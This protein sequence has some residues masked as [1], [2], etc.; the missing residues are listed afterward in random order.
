MP[1]V[2]VRKIAK[3][4]SLFDSYKVKTSTYRGSITWNLSDPS[5][6]SARDYAKREKTAPALRNLNFSEESPQMDPLISSCID[7]M[8]IF[9]IF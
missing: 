6:V 8:H 9:F 2:D 1:S 4:D 7:F 3:W 5:A